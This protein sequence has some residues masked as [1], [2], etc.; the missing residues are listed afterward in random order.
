ML[1]DI[2]WIMCFNDSRTLCFVC[3]GLFRLLFHLKNCEIEC[4]RGLGLDLMDM[5]PKC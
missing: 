4:E 3:I 2:M 5:F 1:L